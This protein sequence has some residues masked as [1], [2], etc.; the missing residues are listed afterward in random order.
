MI[1]IPSISIKPYGIAIYEQYPTAFHRREDDFPRPYRWQPPRR[2]SPEG[3]ISA[4]AARRIQSALKWLLFFSKTKKAYNRETHRWVRF[5][6]SLITLTLSS[7][8]CHSDQVIKSRLFN[9]LLTEL[10]EQN[11]MIHYVWRAEK[12]ENGNIHFHLVTNVFIHAAKLREKWNRIQ[13]KL[14]YVDAYANRM[15]AQIHSFADYYNTF[16]GQANTDILRQRYIH[17]M[18]TRWRNPNST[19][20]H[21]V[22]RVRDLVRYLCKYLCK[23]LLSEYTSYDTIPPHLLVHGKLWGLSQT[24]SALKNVTAVVDRF[25]FDD[26]TTLCTEFAGRIIRHDYCTFIPVSFTEIIRS[27]CSAIL[28]CIYERLKEIGIHMLQLT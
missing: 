8:Q 3:I 2:N 7:P 13:N 24:L 11:G 4:K 1:K 20:I 21:S 10:R 6:I 14:G 26:L 12:Q 19:D 18:A 17:G 25:L 15:N 22:R 27:R 23:N 16:I 28:R 9:Q 5:R